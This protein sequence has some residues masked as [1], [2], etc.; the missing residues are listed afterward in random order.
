[1]AVDP[2]PSV[3]GKMLDHRQNAAGHQAIRHAQPEIGDDLRVG[4]KG[5][6]P[7]RV[8]GIG[9]KQVQTRQAINRDTKIK[10]DLSN[11]VRPEAGGVPAGGRILFI[12]PRICL[13]RR[14]DWP[15][16]WAEALNPPPFLID[17]DGGIRP[18]HR[19]AISP[20]KILH[21]AGR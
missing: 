7:D 4:R 14:K 19:I 17:Q 12:E 18:A 6:V 15:M 9:K 2:R 20:H 13:L 21:L 3:S 11:Q 1:M 16:G 10:Q 5:T 8:N